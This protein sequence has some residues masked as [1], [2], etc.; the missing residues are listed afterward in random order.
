MGLIRL[1]VGIGVLIVLAIAFA[2]RIAAGDASPWDFF[3]FFTNQTS[4]WAGIVFVV[5]GVLMLLGRPVPA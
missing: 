3:G 1:L 4:L 2:E 5:T